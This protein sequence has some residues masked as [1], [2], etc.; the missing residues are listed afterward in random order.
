MY[1]NKLFNFF[2]CSLK[3]GSSTNL[4][5]IICTYPEFRQHFNSTLTD[6]RLDNSTISHCTT[7]LNDSDLCSVSNIDFGKLKIMCLNCCGINRRLQYPE[8]RNLIQKTRYS[9]LD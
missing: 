5:S 1:F 8:F 4:D 9:M 7:E 2:N 3:A 6:S